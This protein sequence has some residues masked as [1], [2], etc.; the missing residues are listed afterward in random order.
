MSARAS[1]YSVALALLLTLGHTVALRAQPPG[2]SAP[3]GPPPS[4]R[5]AAP[6][7]LTGQWVAIVNEDWR[8][9]MMT[10]PKGD[11]PGIPLNAEGRKVADA[12][13][14]AEDGSCNAY[15]APG[16]MRMPTRLRIRWDG[17]GALEVQTDAG[18]QSRRLAFSPAAPGPKSLQGTSVAEWVRPA[19]PVGLGRRRAGPPPAGGYLKVV[20]TNLSPGWLRKNG[21]PY[22]EDTVLTEYFDRFMGPDGTEW[23]MVTAV[24]DDP[25][26]LTA[27]FITS[28]HFRRE[29]RG[30]KW[31]PQPCKG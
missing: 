31:N 7:D 13:D 21:V 16:L 18:R 29:P 30:G 25:I 2:G 9:R 8:W 10:P 26:Y 6:L 22:S 20:T 14:A 5:A 15:G 19:A 4:P 24:V 11:Y 3:Q 23:L 28:S 12:W 17:D 27:R 1:G